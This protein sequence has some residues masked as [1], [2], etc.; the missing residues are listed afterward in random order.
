[1]NRI[2]NS[3]MKFKIL[4]NYKMKENKK[5]QN[6]LK[7]KDNKEKNSLDCNN[8]IRSMKISIRIIFSNNKNFNFKNFKIMP[9]IIYRIKIIKMIYIIIQMK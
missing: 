6:N 8:K 2:K 3:K 4:V 9:I 1:M 5:S 7:M